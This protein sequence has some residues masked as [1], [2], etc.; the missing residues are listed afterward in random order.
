MG[1]YQTILS[2]SGEQK[3]QFDQ[4]C[5]QIEGQFAQSLVSLGVDLS[6]A[7]LAKAAADS[8]EIK[9]P[10]LFNGCALFLEVVATRPKLIAKLAERTG[11]TVKNN[12]LMTVARAATV[13]IVVK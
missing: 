7:T 3:R 6:T 8:L 12:A 13:P 10:E 2:L 4:T 11:L 1:I 5:D 9:I